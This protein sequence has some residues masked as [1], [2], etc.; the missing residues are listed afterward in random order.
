MLD[1]V[2]QVY[3]KG[4]LA[5]TLTRKSGEVRFEYLQ[6][7]ID[8][9]LEPVAT[10]LPLSVKPI[11][12]T[13]GATPAFFAG[14]L[15]EGRRL[16]AIAERAKLSVDD[17]L[18]LLLEIGADL[19]GDV[20]VLAPGIDPSIQREVL[21]LP[22]DRSEVS[23][24]ELR[25]K[26]FG[27]KASGIPG[28]QDKVSSQMLNAPSKTSGQDYIVKFNPKN[29]PFA[30][31]NEAYFLTLAK[32][33]DIE[34]ADFELLTDGQ[35]EHAL[36][37]T[38]FDRIN[39]KPI[40]KS[41]AVEDGA[42]VMGLYPLDKYR[43]D[44]GEMASQMIG[45]CASP[46][47]AALNLFKQL[48]FSWLIG[49]GDAH[50]KNF[51][52]L[53]VAHDDWQVSPAYDLLCTVFYDNDKTMALAIGGED[54]SWSRALLLDTAKKLAVPKAA[55]NRVIDKQLTVLSNLPTQLLSGAL[56]F[57]RDQKIDA[58]NLLKKRA[59]RLILE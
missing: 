44:F 22:R 27:S 9:A 8:A 19:I 21:S 31:E 29:V 34:T 30:V 23:F 48:V 4:V 25:E 7:Y 46:K 51:S 53:K 5:A 6:Q 24:S 18:A 42:Q 58:S 35:G 43:V 56:P 52:I 50:A 11:V 20:Q 28:V 32:K 14:L 12:L 38:R 45:L 26:Y 15:P 2:G 54:S 17:D 3:K 33:C 55:A 59:S 57:R 37:L 41:L 1:S 16:G 47:V 13:N 10:T 36:R 40:K 49:N 39:Q